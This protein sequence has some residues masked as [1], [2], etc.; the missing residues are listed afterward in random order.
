MTALEDQ[1]RLRIPMRQ[2]VGTLPWTLA[3]NGILRPRDRVRL[4]GQ[5]LLLQLRVVPAELRRSLDLRRARLARFDLEEFVVPDTRASHEAEEL[6]ARSPSVVNH[7][8]RTYVWGA[9]LA[10]HDGISYDQEMLYVA[11]L[12]HDIGFAE[13][14]RTADGRPCC[15]TYTGAAA[16]LELAAGAGW[17]QRR[18]DAAA[19]ALTLHANL[20][21]GRRES[22]EAYL[23][24]AGARLDQTGYRHWDLER[25]TVQGVLKR[26]PRQGWK[27]ACCQ[28]MS[29]Q[30]AS[31]RAHFYTRYLAGNRFIM[32]A[33]FEE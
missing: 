30:A 7:S 17:E 5:G 20:Y 11:S 16:V 4:L 8:Y 12:V 3:T 13:A 31:T 25:E 6:C 32:R 15:L 23:L 26:Y 2:S 19:E 1:R 33:P 18:S 14:Q 27:R 28:M 9:I 24:F 21:V 22:P 29:K 10:A